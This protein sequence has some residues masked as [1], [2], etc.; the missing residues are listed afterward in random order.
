MKLISFRHLVIGLCMFAAAGMA[1]ALKPT[2]RIVDSE[3]KLDLETLIPKAFGDWKI[4][5]TIVPLISNPEQQALIKEIY[6]Q[7]LTRTYVNSNGEHIMLSIAYGGDQSDNMAVHKPE[8]CY[9]AQGFQI[10]KN[11]TIGSFATGEGSIPVKRLVA[12]QGR[13][14]EPITYWTTVGD[15]VAVNG[16]KWK[17][18]QLKYG[19][20]GKIPDGLL[21]RI[22]SIQADDTKAYHI[23]DAFTRD[24]LKA[25]SPDGRQRIIGHPAAAS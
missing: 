24:L 12:T 25:M 23:Q 6:N 8:V 18:Q 22:S 13:R 5:E 19:L 9:P 3:P 15:T 17:L 7:T 16:L 4:D 14:I 11:P 10:L 2:V 21:F 20:T 1:L